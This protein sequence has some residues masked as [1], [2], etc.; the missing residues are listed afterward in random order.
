[1]GLHLEQ[2]VVKRIRVFSGPPAILITGVRVVPRGRL[3]L[4][5]VQHLRPIVY[6]ATMARLLKPACASIAH[7]E[8]TKKMVFVKIAPLENILDKRQLAAPNAPLENTYLIPVTPR[9]VPIAKTV[10]L[11]NIPTMIG[12]VMIVPLGN[13][14]GRPV[15]QLVSIAM[16][17]N[18]KIVTVVHPVKP[19]GLHIHIIITHTSEIPTIDPNANIVGVVIITPILPG[20]W[21]RMIRMR[22]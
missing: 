1:M 5:L 20:Q 7:V 8:N 21:V 9:V 17:V 6:P 16:S 18:F 19:V 10:Q 15:Q 13:I 14:K 22:V 11:E 3:V 4:S 2:L 12:F